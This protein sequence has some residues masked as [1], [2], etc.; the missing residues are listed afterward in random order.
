MI[1]RD[2]RRSAGAKK[3]GTKSPPARQGKPRK[4]T[5]KELALYRGLLLEKRRSLLGDMDCLAAEIAS[6][7]QRDG[8]NTPSGTPDQLADFATDCHEMEMSVGLLASEQALLYEISEALQRII[9]GTYGIC[10][11]TGQPIRKARLKAR[12]WTRYCIEHARQREQGRHGS[13]RYTRHAEEGARIAA[14]TASW[15]DVG[16]P[17]LDLSEI[18][19]G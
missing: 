5:A 10:E 8:T 4:P 18:D 11:G 15:D 7:T 1:A 9:D 2:K 6:A 14:G 19:E 13:R 3:A 12:P 16:V 17:N